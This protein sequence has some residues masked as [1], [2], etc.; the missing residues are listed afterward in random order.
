MNIEIIEE[1]YSDEG[2][3]LHYRAVPSWSDC[4]GYGDTPVQAL[5]DLLEHLKADA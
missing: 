1:D 3:D 4:E 5:A 2:T